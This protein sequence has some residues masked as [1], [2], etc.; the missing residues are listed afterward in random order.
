[1][2]R[3]FY[4]R[5]SISRPAEPLFD[6]WINVMPLAMREKIN[7][8]RRWQDAQACLFGK[9]LLSLCLSR[10]YPF[11]SLSDL[12]H[13]AYNRP[14][15]KQG[16][17][18]FNISHSGEH[19]VCA[20]SNTCRVGIDIEEVKAVEL[21]DYSAQFNYSE[22]LTVRAATD[23]ERAFFRIWTQKEA[24]IKANGKGLSL[25]LK[26]IYINRNAAQIESEPWYLQEIPIAEKY[27]CHLATNN[28]QNETTTIISYED[29]SK[30]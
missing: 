16:G 22:W 26:T 21:E 19:I 25:P 1:M 23:Q 12:D 24:L 9:A 30:R 7:R 6:Y 2:V 13:T 3:I 28:P 8:Y 4:T 27:I 14:Y 10:F 29:L 11:L 18:D 20:I 15:F 17:P 5:M